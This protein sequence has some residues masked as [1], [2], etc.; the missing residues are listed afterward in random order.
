MFFRTEDAELAE[1]K[2]LLVFL[3]TS[4]LSAVDLPYGRKRMARIS[5][6]DLPEH[7]CTDKCYLRAESKRSRNGTCVAFNLR[8]ASSSEKKHA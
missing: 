4:L 7:G 6:Q 8:L 1:A 3:A 5:V 2:F